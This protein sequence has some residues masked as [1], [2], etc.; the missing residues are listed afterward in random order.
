MSLLT[1]NNLLSYVYVMLIIIIIIIIII[2]HLSI[3][4]L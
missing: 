3:D 2:N 4:Y 1:I